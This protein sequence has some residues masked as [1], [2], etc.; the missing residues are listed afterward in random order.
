[1]KGQ[2][3]PIFKKVG[4]FVKEMK[5]F[6]GRDSILN[7]PDLTTEDVEVPEWG[8]WVRVRA[9]S[10]KERDIFEASVTGT[11]KKNKRMNLDNVRARLVQMTIVGEDGQPLFKRS[12]IEALGKKSAAALDRVFEVATRLS[13]ISEAD[14]DELTENFD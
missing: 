1:M 11:H 2:V 4:D 9:L 3:S 13:G 12:D 14:V 5:T 6:L 7:A 8:G 10:G